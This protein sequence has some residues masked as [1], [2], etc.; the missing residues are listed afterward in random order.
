MSLPN[1]HYSPILAGGDGSASRCYVPYIIVNWSLV[2]CLLIEEATDFY[3]SKKSGFV[4]FKIQ[5][6]AMSLARV[7]ALRSL[8]LKLSAESGFVWLLHT[9]F[10]TAENVDWPQKR[11]VILNF[12][13]QTTSAT[14]STYD[15]SG[16][17]VGERKSKPEDV[18]LTRPWCAS[19]SFVCEKNRGTRHWNLFLSLKKRVSLKPQF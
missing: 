18:R 2:R 16:L 3:C 15:Y 4:H 17:D 8:N 5:P 11:L 6:V 19:Q 7:T 10:S 12:M 1:F 13:F 14:L 9:F